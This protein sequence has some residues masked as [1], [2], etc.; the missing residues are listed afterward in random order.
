[1]CGAFSIRINPWQV[2]FILDVEP[3]RLWKPIYNARPGEWLPIVTEEQPKNLT[4]AFW[5]FLPHWMDPKKG[6]AVINARAETIRTKPYFRK[7]FQRQRCIIPADGFYEWEKGGKAKVPYFFHRK[8]DKPFAFA[9]VYDQLPGKDDKVGFAII[10]TTP[11][12]TVGRIHD[13]MPVMLLDDQV[14]DWLN[15]DTAVEQ[16]EKLFKPYPDKLMT[17][18]EVSRSVNFARNKGSDVVEPIRSTGQLL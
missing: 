7:S 15:P 4:S 5:G 2:K 12:K 6:R 9:G 14:E 16:A 10:T 11:N 17:S 18:Y 3:L 1:M 8:D 13:R